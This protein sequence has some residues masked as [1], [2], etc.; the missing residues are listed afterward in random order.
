[1]RQVTS[2]MPPCLGERHPA[3][4]DAM[5]AV[6]VKPDLF[7][8]NLVSPS[9]RL[10]ALDELK[11]K[12]R[13]RGRRGPTREAKPKPEPKLP[14]M[15]GLRSSQNN[16]HNHNHDHNLNQNLGAGVRAGAPFCSAPLVDADL[17]RV[18]L[19]YYRGGKVQA[20]TI[21]TGPKYGPPSAILIGEAGANLVLAQLLGWGIPAQIA[22]P[23]IAYD[24]IADIPGLDL[25]RIQ[26][27]TRSRPKGQ[28]CSFTM[29]RGFYYSKAGMFNYER[30]DFD[31]AAFV[32]LSIG[33]VFFC[34]NPKSHV[35]VRRAWMQSST[36]ARDS[37]DLA[38]HAIQRRRRIDQ[39][40]WLAS[41]ND[42]AP[43]PRMEANTAQC[44][45]LSAL[46][47]P[48]PIPASRL[49][50]S[51]VPV[52]VP[53]S[54]PAQGSTPVP[55]SLRAPISAPIATPVP[56]QDPAPA[57]VPV[58]MLAPTS[59][60]APVSASRPG[61]KLAP[62]LPQASE[63]KRRPIRVPAPPQVRPQK[64][65][66]PIPPSQDALDAVD[67]DEALAMFDDQGEYD[68]IIPI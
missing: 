1:M 22:M 58:A 40:S 10:D 31:L 30:D 12:A 66:P 47:R 41:M 32:C 57:P 64:A 13:R 17:S 37:F 23:G 3:T 6:A 49:M 42:D 8:P 51:S 21:H 65:P 15:A 9:A 59:I 46:P 54:V 34:H 28:S 35:S 25:L 24:L 44:P 61:A 43:A 38:L 45:V 56:A 60:P 55:T 39:L 5:P 2:I 62:G 26:V 20:G 63:P 14:I 7:T 36:I 50:P 29:T 68:A 4:V 27:K 18:A 11:P 52:P 19:P 48:A 53:T 67:W 16:D 33:A